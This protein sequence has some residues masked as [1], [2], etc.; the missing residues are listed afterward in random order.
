MKNNYLAK[1]TKKLI[2]GVFVSTLALTVLAACGNKNDNTT[3]QGLNAYT[4]SCGNC[5]ESG[6]TGY[7]FFSAQSTAYNQYGSYGSPARITLSFSG[8]NVANNNY[9]YNNGGYYSSSPAMN[10][11]GKVSAAGTITAN[12][13]IGVN[14]FCPQIPAGTY[15]ITTNSVGQWQ[16]GQVSGLRLLINGSNINAV[17]VINQLQAYDYGSYGYGSSVNNSRIY[18]NMYIESVN[19]YYCQ[20]LVLTL[21]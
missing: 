12:S 7:P 2:S 15:N 6:I 18:G 17:A 16:N 21:Y 13:A 19:G 4:Q 14:N 9:G 1:L 10:Y 11:V 3:N 20:S 8:Q 5:I